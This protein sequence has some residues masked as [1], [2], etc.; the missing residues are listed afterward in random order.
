MGDGVLDEV[1]ASF[2]FLAVVGGFGG[3]D[4]VFESFGFGQVIVHAYLGRN[5]QVKKRKDTQ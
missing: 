5:G 4:A 2:E 3:E 1:A